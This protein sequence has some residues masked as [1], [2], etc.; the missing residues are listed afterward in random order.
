MYN[1][2]QQQQ[3]GF[4]NQ[5][6]QTGFAGGY[7]NQQQFGQPQQPGFY[8][9]PQL[10][11]QATGFYPQQFQQQ[12]GLSAPNLGQQPL[13]SQ[14]T[15]FVQPQATGFIQ[16]QATGFIQPQK[17]GFSQAVSNV[18]ENND[19]K[20][21]S[22]RLS[23]ITVADQTKF[24]HLFRTAV[25]KG[26]QAINGDTAR[27]ILLRSGLQ[28][29]TL[30]EI[31]SLADTNKSGSLLFP[32]FALALHL[33]NLSLKGDSLP[34]VLPE[35]WRNEVQSF[36]DAISFSVPEDPSK[37]LANTPFS[38]FSQS[39][40]P[41]TTGFNPPAPPTTS[42]TAQP[43]GGAFQ[44][45]QTGFNNFA[46]QQPPAPLNSQRTGGG[47]LIPLQPQQTAGLIPTQKTGPLQAQT[48]GFQN[49]LPAQ[50]TGF[51]PQATGL[52]PQT[53]GFQPQA[54]GFQ[55]QAT[56]VQPQATGFQPQATGFQPQATGFQPQQT[57]GYLQS[58]PTGKPGQWGFVSTPT[59]GI[60]GLNAMQEHFLPSS[61]LPSN[62]LQNVMGGS[63]KTNVTWAITKQEKQIYDGIFSAWDKSRKG[64]IDGDVAISIF[65][66][67]GLGRP[68][69]ESIWNLVDSNNR[70]KLNKD[71][72][73]V[74]MHLV[75]RRLNGFELP[76]RLPPELI[77]PSTKYLQDSMDSLKNSLK[78]GGAVKP[79][80]PAPLKAKTDGSRFKNNDED[81]GY[82]SS[83][84][85]R[86]R[87]NA[88]END[89]QKSSV[90]SS[91][92]NDL[93]IDDLK[94]LIREKQI[95]LDALDAEDQDSLNANK[96]LD[97]KNYRDIEFLKSQIKNVQM[98]LND[99]SATRGSFDEKKQ[100]LDKLNYLTRDRV[101]GL[102]S[103]IHAV[104][105]DIAKQK[106]ELYKLRLSKENPDWS[107]DSGESGI[108]GTGPNGEVTDY[109]RKKFKSKQ[110]L[111]QRMAALTG[112]SASSGSNKDLDSKLQ[113]ESEQAQK[114][115]E[116][117]SNMI[118]DI[119]GSIRE[120]EDGAAAFLHV[121]TKDEV[122]S[123]KWENGT[124]V[125]SHVAAFI[126]DLKSMVPPQSSYNGL[127]VSRQGQPQSLDQ[128]Y[129]SASVQNNRSL[130]STPQSTGQN[131]SS[132]S[133]N[134]HS[135]PEDRAAYIKAQAE[136]RMQDR[137][138]KL[139][140]SRP[141]RG[142]P[143]GSSHRVN[144]FPS[145]PSQDEPPKQEPPK[146]EPP[147]QEPP[148]Q[149]PPKLEEPKP[150]SSDAASVPAAAPPS[151]TQESS[152][153]EDE[154]YVAL[155]KQKQEMETRENERKLKKKQEKEARLAKLKKEMEEMK[156]REQKPDSDDDWDDATVP[157]A[158][159]YKPTS[160][161]SSSAAPTPV[162]ED[163]AA[164]VSADQAPV[165]N[166]N[167]VQQPHSS[168][169]FAKM[170]PPNEQ[171]GAD[172]GASSRSNTN[173]F[174]KSAPKE[175][176]IDPKKAEAQ[177]ASQR[178][179]DDNDWSDDDE[180]SSDDEGPNRAGAAKL[181]SLLFGGMSQPPARTDSKPEVAPSVE[182]NQTPPPPT[183][184]NDDFDEDSDDQFATPPTL[185]SQVPPNDL[186]APPVPPEAPPIPS[187]A[188]PIPSEA[189]PIPSEA[190]PIPSEA[191]PI[192]SE[193]PPIP[194][195]IP[196][197]PPPP[198]ASFG[199]PPPAP[200]SAP[201]GAP[202]APPPPPPALPSQPSSSGPPLG[203]A[204]D[205][206]ALLG[207]IQGGK[208]LKKVD[209]NQKHIADGAT[210]GR[211]L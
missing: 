142:S 148:K 104:N 112:K 16:P 159:T 61:Q 173:P 107:P 81:V 68:D 80:K 180:N 78:G 93:T 156:K 53:T 127:D 12:H 13:Q 137:L 9:Q 186:I 193:A 17:T 72:F 96:S 94:K 101:P 25:P 176:S 153:D 59:G 74:V 73:A 85:H 189:P 48:T 206:G 14:A 20:I 60:P 36:V 83:S 202:P 67:S 184:A 121:S 4:N 163:K 130:E 119:E 196:P 66:K 178:G 55:P 140:I 209:E 144:Q 99:S 151:A 43:T 126:R 49:Q 141:H 92:D 204:P 98:S 145:S 26:E 42:F 103:K 97:E 88:A 187:E 19:L 34:A 188:P 164:P 1:P 41:Q 203:G 132:S 90:K 158:Q 62:N 152:D 40:A 102:I 143:S 57:G 192:P 30:A 70:G 6:Q 129:P 117:Q 146:Q 166:N 177:R 44:P 168:N 157:Q 45:V 183:A 21:P 205:I 33:C 47:S 208:S 207:Q 199:A 39:L 108:V 46:N 10:Q 124:D 58:Q 135:S 125:S 116:N 160:Q 114:E 118:N 131:S 56:G 200:P 18:S 69:L 15:G 76:L 134:N 172:S 150:I 64:F 171:N 109:D 65:G 100:L 86:R 138:A 50:K 113:Q 197:P 139:G 7:P 71:E 175:A 22:I 52:Q 149:E 115:R 24:E 23:F 210:V 3:T 181:A 190:P 37:V 51:Q 28:P 77:P 123:N 170:Q 122:G 79:A 95:L 165:L 128:N 105:K 32:E 91:R 195:S 31:W 201:S 182:K 191:P 2:Y 169:P 5:Q 133:L 75:Y 162:T 110:L 11:N 27:D 63:L 38:S 155:M 198:P 211:V 29:V 82:V 89:Q 120:L 136:K 154:E 185:S 54:T 174:F 8:P 111:K 161:K 194:S 167:L 84:R 87:S 147:K 179:L 106:V 35:K